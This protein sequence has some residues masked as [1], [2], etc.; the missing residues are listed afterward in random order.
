MIV[1]ASRKNE[2]HWFEARGHWRIDVQ[3][4]GRRKSF[5]SSTRGR[6]GKIECGRKA[7]EWLEGR[8]DPEGLNPR[9]YELWSDYHADVA[10]TTGSAN[11]TKVEQMGRLYLLP[12]LGSRR[13]AS[14]TLQDWQ[15]RITEAGERGLSKKT[16]ANIRGAITALYRYARRNRVQME[17]PEFLTVPRDASV[18]ERHILQPDQIR[19]LFTVDWITHYGRQLSCWCINSWRFDALTGLRRG[20]LA[21]LQWADITDNVLFVSRSINAQ[22]QETRGKNENA[23]RYLVLSPRMN[24]VLDDQ[25]KMLRRIGLV[26]PWI[27]PGEDGDRINPDKIYKEWRT[28][29]SQ[30]GIESNI[31]EL[32]HTMISLV[33]PEIPDA[34]LKPLVGHSDS[35]DT[36]IYRHVVDGNAARASALID[37]VF[38]RILN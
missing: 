21:G 5:Y 28:Y 24:A 8:G 6:K 9:F 30:H 1:M 4:N 33:S 23:R 22:Q 10:R 17:R 34:L 19:R 16:C 37:D 31:H 15:D 2:A 25:R 18:G 26:S 7:D 13:I 36:N 11:S 38:T 14:I 27:F 3:A 29:R 12:A 32:R 20:E 35:T